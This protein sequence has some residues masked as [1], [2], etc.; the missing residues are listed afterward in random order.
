MNKQPSTPP[1]HCVL[2]T[3]NYFP[4]QKGQAESL[5]LLLP[6]PA[7]EKCME[8]QT[9]DG[10]NQVGAP[11]SASHRP[12]IPSEEMHRDFFAI[13]IAVSF[14]AGSAMPYP[15]VNETGEHE[16]RMPVVSRI[17]ESN[18]SHSPW[19]CGRKRMVALLL[20]FSPDR[21]SRQGTHSP[22]RRFRH[23]RSI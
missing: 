15:A 9:E 21:G 1:V 5:S 12:A 23:W 8:S 17:P 18:P 22:C 3:I 10:A 4:K 2:C 16:G 11:V 14:A 13:C 19:A 6:F 7:L 20:L